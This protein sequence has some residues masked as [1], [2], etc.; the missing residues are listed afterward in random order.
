MAE[1]KLYG[2][3]KYDCA[4]FVLGKEIKTIHPNGTIEPVGYDGRIFEPILIV[5]LEKGIKLQK[6]LDKATAKYNRKQKEALQELK[7]S[8]KDILN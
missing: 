7:D 8:V 5:P 2:F 6:K 4:P 3:W 1:R